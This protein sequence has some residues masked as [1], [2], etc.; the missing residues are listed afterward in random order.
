MREDAE[1]D[2]ESM[3]QAE[4]GERREH[5]ERDDRAAMST[6]PGASRSGKPSSAVGIALAWI[7]GPGHRPLVVVDV[8][9]RSCSDGAVAPTTTILPRT[10]AGSNLP[11]STST[12]LSC[13]NVSGRPGSR[14]SRPPPAEARSRA[15]EHL[16]RGDRRTTRGR[17]RSRACGAGCRR[18]RSRRSSSPGVAR[19]YPRPSPPPKIC[20]APPGATSVV[21]E[22]DAPRCR[23]APPR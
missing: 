9:R 11:C 12:K 16:G 5:A 10:S 20:V 23:R 1:R 19:L 17:S 7:S 13:R 15:R 4:R 21:A 3:P 8:A 18:R 2:D 6:Q 14:S 22:D